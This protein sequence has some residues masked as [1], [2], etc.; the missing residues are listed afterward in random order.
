MRERLMSAL[1]SADS[2]AEIDAIVAVGTLHGSKARREDDC[3]ALVR[4]DHFP[5]GL[6]AGLL[7]HQEEFAAFPISSRLTK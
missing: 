5:F 4:S 7:L 1:H 2:V 6:R 3:L